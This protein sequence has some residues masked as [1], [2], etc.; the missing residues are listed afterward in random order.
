MFT[1]EGQN[2]GRPTPA[3][4]LIDEDYCLRDWCCDDST[5]N[6]FN[7]KMYACS[8]CRGL[9]GA[10]TQADFQKQVYQE[11]GIKRTCRN[12]KGI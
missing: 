5:S 7:W 8:N 4:P 3:I 6:I 1:P 11:Y 10:Y 2:I 12:G 9:I